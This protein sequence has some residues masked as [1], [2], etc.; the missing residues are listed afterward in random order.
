VG[1]ASYDED[2]TILSD[3]VT[4]YQHDANGSM[5]ARSSML[6][7][8]WGYEYDAESRLKTVRHNGQVVARYEYD[9]FGRRIWKELADGSRTYYQYADEGLIAEYE[10]DGDKIRG[11]GYRPDQQ[12]ERQPCGW[13]RTESISTFCTAIWAPL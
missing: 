9:P 1:E 3:D 6:D 13:S 10:E 7:G 12:W 2:N 11:Y 8:D 5:T 4:L